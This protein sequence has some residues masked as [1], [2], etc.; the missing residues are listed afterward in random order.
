MPAELGGR[1]GK[2]RG[3][4]P[5]LLSTQQGRAPSTFEWELLQRTPRGPGNHHHVRT[6]ERTHCQRHLRPHAAREPRLPVPSHSTGCRFC[7]GTYL[8][9]QRDQGSAEQGETGPQFR[10]QLYARGCQHF[11]DSGGGGIATLGAS[12][13]KKSCSVILGGYTWK[14]E[15]R[16]V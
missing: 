9:S 13:F 15:P 10:G 5:R 7:D 2:G 6:G 11:A 1:Y 3:H 14:L 16:L 8:A 4:S 12:V